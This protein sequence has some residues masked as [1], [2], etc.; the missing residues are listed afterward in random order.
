MSKLELQEECRRMKRK[1]SGNKA[2]LRERL[3]EVFETN[4]PRL[5]DEMHAAAC[6][7]RAL[8]GQRVLQGRLH[9]QVQQGA[10]PRPERRVQSL[11]ERHDGA[12]G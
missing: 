6:G 12:A 2:D 11:Q 3:E 5:A 7:R 4:G 10:A 9:H 1:V 8:L